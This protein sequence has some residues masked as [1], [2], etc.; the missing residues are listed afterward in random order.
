MVD[1]MRG[2]GS[3]KREFNVGRESRKLQ[4]CVMYLCL[5][6][7]SKERDA[8]VT[9]GARGVRDRDRYEAEDDVYM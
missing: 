6:L 2:E 9:D 5:C 3:V 8:R 7:W 4:H 1:L